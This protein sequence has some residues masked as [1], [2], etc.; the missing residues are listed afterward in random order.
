MSDAYGTGETSN[1]HQTCGCGAGLLHYAVN[2][3]HAETGRLVTRFC[4]RCAADLVSP[5]VAAG[6]AATQSDASELH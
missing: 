4:R 1:A 3:V 6:G 5:K 2:V